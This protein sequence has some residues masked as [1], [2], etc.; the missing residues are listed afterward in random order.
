MKV[1]RANWPAIKSLLAI[2]LEKQLFAVLIVVV[3][4]RSLQ[5]VSMQILITQM[6]SWKSRQR[7]WS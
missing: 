5:D 4:A 3:R 2:L 7:S 1:E 6:L